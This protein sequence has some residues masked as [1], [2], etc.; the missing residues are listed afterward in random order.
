MIDVENNLPHMNLHTPL[1]KAA[2]TLRTR[3]HRR[4]S[5]SVDFVRNRAKNR[6]VL[7][8]NNSNDY[9]SLS[10]NV[11]TMQKRPAFLP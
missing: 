9:S 11:R 2:I 6:I 1:T 3:E 8:C 10:S 5:K 7:N 4:R